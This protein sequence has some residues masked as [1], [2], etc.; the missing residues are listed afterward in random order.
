MK[1]CY[2]IC[3]VQNCLRKNVSEY[4]LSEMLGTKRKNVISMRYLSAEMSTEKQET[5]CS[6]RDSTW[7]R[8][9]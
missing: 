3:R 2:W 8:A 6:L 5:A 4:G 1:M 7:A 9:S